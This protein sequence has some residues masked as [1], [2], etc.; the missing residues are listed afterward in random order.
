MTVVVSGAYHDTT[1]HLALDGAKPAIE[2]QGW[3]EMSRSTGFPFRAWIIL[4]KCSLGQ[5]TKSDGGG[6]LEG[7]NVTASPSSV[8]QLALL[9]ATCPAHSLIVGVASIQ[10][11]SQEFGEKIAGFFGEL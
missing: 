8:S 4:C 9:R 7:E 1:P 6:R 11:R 10:P 3:H 2:Q 5:R